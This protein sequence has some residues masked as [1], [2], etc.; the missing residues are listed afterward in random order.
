MLFKE[1]LLWPSERDELAASIQIFRMMSGK[2]FTRMLG[3]LG[4][5]CD[6]GAPL[7]SYMGTGS[8]CQSERPSLHHSTNHSQ[9]RPASHCP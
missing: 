6:A 4:H 1:V 7:L 5:R 9:P 2:L 3:G 8:R